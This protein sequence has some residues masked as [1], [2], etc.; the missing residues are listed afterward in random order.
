M[1]L[2]FHKIKFPEI[3]LWNLSSIKNDTANFEGYFFK[4]LEFLEFELH[5]KLKFHKGGRL[6]NISQTIVYY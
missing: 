1:K 2:E 5:N 6:L 3:F 4:E